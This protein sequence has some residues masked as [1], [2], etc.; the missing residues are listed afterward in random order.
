MFRSYFYASLLAATIGISFTS[1]SAAI[2][3]PDKPS[4]NG[5][6]HGQFK[7]PPSPIHPNPAFATSGLRYDSPLDLDAE[8]LTTKHHLYQL[9]LNY[10]GTAEGGYYDPHEGAWIYITTSRLTDRNQMVDAFDAAFNKVLAGE[11]L[12]TLRT[13]T[14]LYFIDCATNYALCE[15]GIPFAAARFQK[16]KKK[17]TLPSL[18]YLDDGGPCTARH[19]ECGHISSWRCTATYHYFELPLRRLPWSRNI[20]VAQNDGSGQFVVVPA[21]PSSTEQIRSLIMQREAFEASRVIGE[22]EGSDGIWKISVVPY[23]SDKRT[24]SFDKL[25]LLL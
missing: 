1:S 6:I 5:V 17:L 8:L 7:A 11:D 9:V 22:S 4:F 21:F 15:Q 3:H 12:T 18:I 20:K 25:R 23:D 10:D 16:E 24:T 19:M 14:Y 2:K 13:R